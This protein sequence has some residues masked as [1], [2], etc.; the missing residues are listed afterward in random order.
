MTEAEI[1]TSGA[2]PKNPG[3]EPGDNTPNQVS[4]ETHRKLLAEKKKRD[5]ELAQMK[6]RLDAFELDRKKQDEEK[7]LSE[8]NFQQLLKNRE[9]ELAKERESGKKLQDMVN[10]SLKRRAF[11]DSVNGAID[12]Q[13]WS[14]IDLSTIAIDP[15]TNMPDDA[16]VQA[17]ARDFEKKFPLVLK[18]RDGGPRLPTDA[19]RGSTGLT[20]DE[21]LRLPAEEM[22]KRQKE[23]IA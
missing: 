9:E 17:S 20:Y 12:D 10:N 21:W 3:G 4:Y 5:E 14:L 7:L 8:K 19:P 2:D 16:S 22:R 11:L 6:Q 23:V 18:R 1:G 15:D 13:Y